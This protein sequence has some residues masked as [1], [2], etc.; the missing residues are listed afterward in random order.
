MR[1]NVLLIGFVA[2][3]LLMGSAWAA[4]SKHNSNMS[5]DMKMSGKIV[6]SNNSELVLSSTKNGKSEKETF[7][8]NPQTKTS[9]A[10]TAGEKAIVHYKNENGQKV[11]TMVSAHKATSSKTK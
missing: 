2:G 7:V 8:V 6:S 11:A 4:T 5:G 1:K 3:L 9:G 10:L